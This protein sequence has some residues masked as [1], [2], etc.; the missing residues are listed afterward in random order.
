[1]QHNYSLCYPRSSCALCDSGADTC[2]VGKLAK[3]ENVSNK[4]TNLV[5]YD[6][7]TTKSYSLPM[8][9]ALIKTLSAK[10]VPLLFQICEAVFN[11]ISY[12]TL[13]SEYQLRDH[14]MIV[15]FVATK[16]LIINGTRG[17]HALY[18]SSVVKGLLIDRGGLMGLKLYP[19]KKV[20]KIGIG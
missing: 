9:T 17:T 18:I 2:V 6:P 3:I 20:M 19:L 11:R 16:H 7:Q 1:M 5:E 4:T 13:I 8:V 15:D 14:G 12:S 10:N